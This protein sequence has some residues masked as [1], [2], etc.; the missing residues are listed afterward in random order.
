MS[1]LWF[2]VGIGVILGLF[3]AIGITRNQFMSQKTWVILWT[4]ISFSFAA[5]ILL[6]FILYDAS[7][8]DFALG[9]SLGFVVAISIHVL[10][11]T[12]EEIQKEQNG[13]ATAK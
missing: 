8:I 12:L 6:A 7:L 3:A 10:H 2:L 13:A 1:L 5:F 9:G 4:I 11:H